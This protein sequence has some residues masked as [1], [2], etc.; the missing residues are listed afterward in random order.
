MQQT[1]K[2]T[3]RLYHQQLYTVCF[4]QNFGAAH[5]EDAAIKKKQEINLIL[6]IWICKSTV[7]QGAGKYH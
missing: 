6:Q 2:L 3:L 4:V 5:F 1:H 7:Q